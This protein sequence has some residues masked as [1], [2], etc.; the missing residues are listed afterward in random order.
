MKFD[1]DYVLLK[2]KLYT[3]IVGDCWLFEGYLQSSGHGQLRIDSKLYSTH[4]LSAYV[5]LDLDLDDSSIQVNHKRNCF[6]S[7]CWNPEHLYLG[8]QQDN[9]YD[10]IALGNK[11]W[12][13]SAENRKNK[14]KCDRGHEFTKENTYITPKGKRRC[15]QCRKLRGN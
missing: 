7:N 6:N 4:R 8:T 1:K 10:A 15:R 3:K 14:I 11:F 2:L 5:Y 13:K 9:M 12:K